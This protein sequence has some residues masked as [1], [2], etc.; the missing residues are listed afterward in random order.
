MKA[1][2]ITYIIDTTAYQMSAPFRN[3]VIGSIPSIGY[4]RMILRTLIA[5]MIYIETIASNVKL[6][7]N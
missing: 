1:P 4:N 5:M 2:K 6:S 7:G 3:G